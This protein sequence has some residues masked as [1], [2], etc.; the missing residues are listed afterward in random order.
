VV[1]QL[2]QHTVRIDV[3]KPLVFLDA[4]FQLSKSFAF[5]ELVL[6]EPQALVVHVLDLCLELVSKFLGGRESL[7][8]IAQFLLK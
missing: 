2:V 8:G 3:L 6:L 1:H 5:V 4:T 7:L